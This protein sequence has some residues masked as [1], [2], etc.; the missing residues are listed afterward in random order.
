M[1]EIMESEIK[2]ESETV[3]VT[4]RVPRPDRKYVL[5]LLLGAASFAFILFC[6]ELPALLG[7]I[8]YRTIIGPYHMWWAPN[9]PDPELFAIHRPH[10][11]QMGTARGG[12]AASIYQIPQ[13]DMT[14]FQWDVTYDQHGFR[15]PTDLESADMVVIGDS[16]VED[17][18]VP[19]DELLTTRLATLQ[20]KTTANLGQATY[21]PLQE[22][23]VLKRYALPLHPQLVIWL[24]SEDS[25]VEDV[26]SYHQTMRNKPTFW[27]AFWARSFTRSAAM[28]VRVLIHPPSKA[29]G[30][31]YSGAF[32]TAD[33][34]S[35]NI[36]FEKHPPVL[37]GE[38]LK[39]I[40]ESVATVATAQ[41]LLAAQGA[42]LI[43]VF[44]PM[45]YTVYRS[46]C[47]YPPESKA[48][49]WGSNDLAERLRAGL[50]SAS[51]QTGFV[52]LTPAFLQAA[53]A[54]EVAYYPDD[55]HWNPSGQ[56]IAAETLNRYL[57]SDLTR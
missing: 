8:D 56:K 16:F 54:G 17:L 21:G 36:Y 18:T 41:K 26:I 57:S 5:L 52:D 55:L 33:G 43:F 27:K 46:F 51:P 25:D 40:D 6:F 13:S 29:S 10:A 12:D 35:V 28:L 9:V 47:H 4:E 48:G 1:P 24:F 22:L 42:R 14:E 38:R 30:R 45:K 44:V 20:G 50:A 19:Y 53:R 15:N 37:N 23:V 11:R 34:K 7:V 2:F 39:A 31:N 32:Q 49:T 3:A